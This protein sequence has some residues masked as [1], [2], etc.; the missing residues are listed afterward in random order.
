MF[1]SIVSLHL[2]AKVNEGCVLFLHGLGRLY[3]HELNLAGER[4]L[5]ARVVLDDE[6][7]VVVEEAHERP[8]D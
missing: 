3:G 8:R 5:D 1:A 4:V 7:V 6:P 2:V